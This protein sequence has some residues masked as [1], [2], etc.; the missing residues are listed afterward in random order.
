MK[1]QAFINIYKYTKISL[2]DQNASKNESLEFIKGNVQ[3]WE[4]CITY[5]NVFPIGH[6]EVITAMR[7]G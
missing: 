1:K 4:I 3:N 5:C 7:S 6:S 2:I